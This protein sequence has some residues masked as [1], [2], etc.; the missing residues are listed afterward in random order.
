LEDWDWYYSWLQAE[1]HAHSRKTLDDTLK[2]LVA[3][4]EKALTAT[5]AFPA[6]ESGWL[7]RHEF[8]AVINDLLRESELQPA[9][10][11]DSIQEA[12][13]SLDRLATIA[14]ALRSTLAGRPKVKVPYVSSSPVLRAD[15]FRRLHH[16]LYRH[17]LDTGV[18]V[19][20]LMVELVLDLQGKSSDHADPI[21]RRRKDLAR[22]IKLAVK[23]AKGG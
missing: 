5:Q 20:S 7:A 8:N 16:T 10:F 15:F 18:G 9:Y 17:G 6:V 4:L 13:R 21:E 2:K 3:A 11:K 23:P 1:Q 22:E 19:N 12:V 14:R